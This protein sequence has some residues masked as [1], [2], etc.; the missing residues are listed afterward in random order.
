MK[1]TVDKQSIDNGDR[2][3]SNIY[4]TDWLCLILSLLFWQAGCLSI[5][6]SSRDGQ[7]CEEEV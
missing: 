7:L 5:A 4:E 1:L 3:F 6:L 2:N